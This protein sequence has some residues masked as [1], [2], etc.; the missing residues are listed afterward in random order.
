MAMVENVTTT[1][2]NLA[3]LG[4]RGAEFGSYTQDSARPVISQITQNGVLNMDEGSYIEQSLEG[5]KD[6]SRACNRCWTKSWQEAKDAARLIGIE[7]AARDEDL[8]R[9]AR[10]PIG[11]VFHPKSK[12]RYWR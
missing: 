6:L 8:E 12:P 3:R 4:Y 1:F 11:P 7:N 10:K 2:P 5:Q 9:R